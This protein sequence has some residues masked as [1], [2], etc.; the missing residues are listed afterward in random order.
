MTLLEARKRVV[1]Y[2]LVSEMR[3]GLRLTWIKSLLTEQFMTMNEMQ[4][5]D[6]TRTLRLKALSR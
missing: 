1:Q 6:C 5:H 3:S 4:I 2:V